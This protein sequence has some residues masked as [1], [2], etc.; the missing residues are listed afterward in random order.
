MKNALFI[1]PIITFG[2][3][4]LTSEKPAPKSEPLF[5]TNL[6]NASY[7]PAVWSV[8]PDGVLTATADKEIW[9]N[10][11]YEN[12]TLDLEFKTDHGTNSGVIVYCTDRQNWIPNS[13]EIQIADDHS[14]KWG[15]SPTYFQCGA[16]FGHLPAKWQKV[17]KKPGEWNKMTITCKGKLITVRLNGR[18]VTKMDMN[19]WKSGTKNPDGTEI[20]SWL[21]KPF[22][23][24]PTKGY[25]GLQGKHG[26]SQIWFRNVTIKEL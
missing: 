18:D 5:T 20:P 9:T 21:P 24:L 1:I 19:I 14:E 6:S 2:Y 25:I 3:L 10:K 11:E 15:T 17:V 8:E 7:D 13:V 4:V 16:V 26:D 22:A 23:E 12:F